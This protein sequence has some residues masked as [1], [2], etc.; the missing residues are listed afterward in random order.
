MT[1][2]AQ[3]LIKSM[4]KGTLI[5]A[6]V[7]L[8]ST[9]QNLATKLLHLGPDPLVVDFCLV[10]WFPTKLQSPIILFLPQTSVQGIIVWAGVGS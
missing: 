2:G 6:L 4:L 3:L 8:I 1:L 7:G 5:A 9:V 10:L